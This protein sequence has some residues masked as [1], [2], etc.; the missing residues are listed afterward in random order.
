MIVAL[1]V[2]AGALGA[3]T[4]GEIGEV[5]MRRLGPGWPWGTFVVNLLGAFALGLVVDALGADARAVLGTGFLGGFT[6]YSAFAVETV[7]LAER[8]R[9][10]AAV[11]YASAS[12]VLGTLAALGGIEV[13]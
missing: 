9:T 8:G 10:T 4:R 11:A 2:A 1:A 13:A 5:C 3:L 12:L 6:T 7:L